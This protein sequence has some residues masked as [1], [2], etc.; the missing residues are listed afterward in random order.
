MYAR[1][2]RSSLALLLLLSL[3]AGGLLARTANPAAKPDPRA[4]GLTGTQRLEALMERV[5]I[6][7]LGVKT[8]EARFVQ[9]RESSLLV[10]A[11]Q[12]TGT[13]SYAVPGRVR[14]EY[15]RPTRSRW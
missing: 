9:N 3:S 13:F 15:T 12:S 14:W 7:Q 10:A 1:R 5:R 6:E 11:E 2:K 8:L 4:A